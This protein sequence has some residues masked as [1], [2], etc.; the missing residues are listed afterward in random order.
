MVSSESEALQPVFGMR[1]R[2]GALGIP[3]IVGYTERLKQHGFE[4]PLRIVKS[5]RRIIQKTEG[6]PPNQIR[7]QVSVLRQ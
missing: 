2:Y 6:L 1:N 3:V 7:I 4:T 5:A